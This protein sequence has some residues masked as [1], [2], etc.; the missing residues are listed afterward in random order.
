MSLFVVHLLV[1]LQDRTRALMLL[2]FQQ[3]STALASTDGKM[4][5][6]ARMGLLQTWKHNHKAAIGQTI[7]ETAPTAP[8]KAFTAR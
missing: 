5:A 1:F 8:Y 6:V 4:P 7:A 2:C 3:V